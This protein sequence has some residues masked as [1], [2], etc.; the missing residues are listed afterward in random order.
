MDHLAKWHF[1]WIVHEI[2]YI[3]SSP[4]IIFCVFARWIC[5]KTQNCLLLFSHLS[6]GICNSWFAM[7]KKQ[8]WGHP[9]THFPCI[10]EILL[11]SKHIERWIHLLHASNF[12]PITHTNVPT[13]SLYVKKCNIMLSFD[14]SLCKIPEWCTTF[15]MFMNAHVT[16]HDFT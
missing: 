11:P 9:S 13:F 2:F 15:I 4:H 7:N 5:L 6:K 10:H 1:D 16:S 12:T 3:Q 14:K 8:F